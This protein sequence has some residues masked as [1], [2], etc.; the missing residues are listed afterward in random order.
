MPAIVNRHIRGSDAPASAYLTLP[1]LPIAGI[2]LH[3]AG[4]GAMKPS[5][6]VKA[7]I[8]LGLD[9][10][11]IV[12]AAIINFVNLMTARAAR[13][14]VEIGVR[15]AS[16][17]ARQDLILQFVGEAMLYVALAMIV[18][19]GLVAA[20]LPEFN[21]ILDRNIIF[22][23]WRDPPVV[24]ASVIAVLATGVLA[25][26]YPAFVLSAV[27]PVAALKGAM[28]GATGS[29]AIRQ[30]LVTLQSTIL[31]SL[32]I[33]TGVIYWQTNY[34]MNEGMR[35]NK[36]LVLLIE[37][38]INKPCNTAFK[39]EI[40]ALPNVRAAACSLLAPVANGVSA[41]VKA[42]DGGSVSIFFSPIDF[43][44]FEVYGLKPISGRFFSRDHADAVTMISTSQMDGPIVLN[45]TAVRRLGF[46]SNTAAI[47]KTINWNRLLNLNGRFGEMRP[48]EIIGVAPDF[49]MG[50]VR[51]RIEPTVYYID[52]RLAQLLHVRLRRRSDVTVTLEAIDRLWARFGDSGPITRYFL[53]EYVRK[54]YRTTTRQAQVFAGFT[55]IAIFIASLGLL[56][57]AAF[58]AEQRT[59]EI[60][61]RK[62]LGAGRADIIRH[63]LWQ[64]TKPV[65]WANLIAWPIT[66]LILRYWLDGFAYHINLSFEMFLAAGVTAWV[67]ASV[68]VVWHILRVAS[69]TPASAIRYE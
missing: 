9:G 64:F 57:L 46:V 51:E 32:M 10:V 19:V 5:G 22:N 27:R 45:E 4:M 53:D 34:A 42:K 23:F 2:H 47:G 68:T 12:F 3:R 8:A 40:R 6:S 20:L 37:T 39:D 7:L 44:F 18:A 41:S 24:I 1:L 58:T 25:G 38:S 56:G 36:D 29:G 66:Y 13:R 35:I 43:E 55:I 49:P 69:I 65:L 14:A 54:L 33:S 11:L 30:I 61:V 60:G 52:P 48:S 59:K 31:I 62:A 21:E 16:G 17:A 63:L 26:A 67:I 50:T 28:T 15:K